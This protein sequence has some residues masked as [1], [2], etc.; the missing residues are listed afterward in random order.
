VTPFALLPN[1]LKGA[2]RHSVWA[3]HEM[4]SVLALLGEDAH[5]LMQGGGLSAL[6]NHRIIKVGKD[7]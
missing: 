1:S 7:L 4:R 3:G 5:C 6:K 2:F